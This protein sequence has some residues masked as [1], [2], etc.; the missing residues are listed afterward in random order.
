M[1]RAMLISLYSTGA[2]GQHQSTST[3][4]AVVGVLA[5]QI[6]KTTDKSTTERLNQLLADASAAPN[7]DLLPDRLTD[8][9][10][11]GVTLAMVAL[12]L[13]AT[14]MGKRVA[15]LEAAHQQQ[16]LGLSQR[17]QSE[18]FRRLIARGERLDQV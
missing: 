7:D 2:M 16:Q 11:L 10:T 4:N 3:I 13:Y 14:F 9:L 1:R 12:V 8:V 15:R 6:K 18:N 5:E 17:V